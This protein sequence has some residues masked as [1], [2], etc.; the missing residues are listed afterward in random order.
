MTGLLYVGLCVGNIVGP[1]L[2]K[3]KQAPYYHTGLEANMAVLC[4][5]SGLI[6]LQAFYLSMLNKRN[7]KRREAAGKTGRLVDYSLEA[8]SKWKALRSEQA[9]RDQSEGHG[10]R[11]HVEGIDDLTDLKNE[12]FIYSL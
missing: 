2:Y 9:A 3:K 5:L 4:I 6:L 12:D 8:S 7:V 1:Q 11:Q 10:E